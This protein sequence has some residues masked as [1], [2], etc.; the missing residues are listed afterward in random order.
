MGFSCSDGR[1]CNNGAG[2]TA[3]DPVEADG[4]A[5]ASVDAM[6]ARMGNGQSTYFDGGI[7]AAKRLTQA[8]GVRAGQ[9]ARDAAILMLT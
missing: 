4:I 2:L 8:K 9:A 7:T 5:G 3:L 1:Y 6:T